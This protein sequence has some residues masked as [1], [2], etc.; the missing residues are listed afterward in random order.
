VTFHFARSGIDRPLKVS[1]IFGVTSGILFVSTFLVWYLMFTTPK[2]Y[3]DPSVLVNVMFGIMIS[4]TYGVFVIL[5]SLVIL[6]ARMSIE[7][8][9]VL[10]LFV[11]LASIFAILGSLF[12]LSVIFLGPLG[13]DWQF[14]RR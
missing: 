5:G 8:R 13:S 14:H 3:S 4:V 1:G 7:L 6:F 2:D 10:A 11:F 12:A 9:G